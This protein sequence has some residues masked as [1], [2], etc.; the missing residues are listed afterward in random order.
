MGIFI[1]WCSCCVLI[2]NG[3]CFEDAFLRVGYLYKLFLRDVR[4]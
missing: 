4:V 1:M 3:E 2:A